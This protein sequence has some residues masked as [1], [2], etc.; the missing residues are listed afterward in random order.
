MTFRPVFRAG[1]PLSTV[2]RSTQTFGGFNGGGVPN[3]VTFATVDLDELGIVGVGPWPD[4]LALTRIG[5]YL[6]HAHYENVMQIPPLAG[7]PLGPRAITLLV[8]GTTISSGAPDD[9]VDGFL[10]PSVEVSGHFEITAF[11]LQSWAG[12]V[13]VRVNVLG[14]E[15]ASG[16]SGYVRLGVTLLNP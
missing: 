16:F 6:V 12:E 10:A 9:Q 1:T 11:D 14:Y 5:M 4:G 13:P 15:S 3:L 7:D 8:N 2:V